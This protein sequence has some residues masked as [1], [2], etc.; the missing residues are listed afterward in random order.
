MHRTG[1]QGHVLHGQRYLLPISLVTGP[2]GASRAS[3][4]WAGNLQQVATANGVVTRV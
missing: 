1:R 3:A 2:G 4:T